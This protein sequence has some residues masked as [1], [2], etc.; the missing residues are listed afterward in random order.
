ML[1]AFIGNSGGRQLTISNSR[2]MPRI[3]AFLAEVRI[4][5]NLNVNVRIL[6]NLILCFRVIISHS[7]PLLYSP[8]SFLHP[9]NH[10]LFLFYHRK[11]CS[12]N[13]EEKYGS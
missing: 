8:L 11:P 12:T 4:P 1:V 7:I 3:N 5:L 10:C 9:S 2:M 13:H 6:L